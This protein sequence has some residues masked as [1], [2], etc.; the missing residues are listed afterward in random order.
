MAGDGP[1]VERVTAYFAEHDRYYEV[2]VHR[3]DDGIAMLFR[4]VT[5]T[6]VAA[7]AG[8]AERI[9]AVL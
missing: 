9:D 5:A 2:A 6:V 4:D 8:P 1:P 3:L 7:T